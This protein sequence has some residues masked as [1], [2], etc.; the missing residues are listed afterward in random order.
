MEVLIKIVYRDKKD[1]KICGDF[2][3]AV[4][5]I[6]PIAAEKLLKLINLILAA[7]NLAEVGKF[8]YRLHRL[9]GS[10]Q[11]QYALDIGRKLGWRLIVIP[12]DETGAELISDGDALFC[13][14]VKIVLVW[15]ISKHYE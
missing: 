15:E 13:Q 9:S 14:S 5:K 2:R 6:G 8:N 3:A 11:N 10:R 4:K 7:E 1:E 12:L